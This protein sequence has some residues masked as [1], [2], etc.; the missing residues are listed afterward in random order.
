MEGPK[1]KGGK[2]EG[3]GGAVEINL[4]TLFTL[5]ARTHSGSTSLDQR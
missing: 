2:E 5:I 3:V 1:K 4:L